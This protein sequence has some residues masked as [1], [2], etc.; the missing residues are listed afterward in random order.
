MSMLI[1]LSSFT[2]TSKEEKRKSIMEDLLAGSQYA[3]AITLQPS[4]NNSLVSYWVVAVNN[5]NVIYKLPVTETNFIL[6]MQG[7]QYSKANLYGEDMFKKIEMDSCFYKYSDKN[8]E[9]HPL[10]LYKLNDLWTLRYN[11]N[12]TCPVGCTPFDGMRVEGLA[13][14]KTYPSDA[15]MEI[16][17]D[18]QIQHYT[19]FI[20]GDNM[21]QIF[22]DINNEM[23]KSEYENAK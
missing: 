8:V 3:F 15:Q 23:W 9:C 17:K 4:A 1:L 14:N 13:A 18:Y 21:F 10:S 19:D 16:L 22:S 12:P 5:G 2:L 6:Q 11:R 20:Y 7:K